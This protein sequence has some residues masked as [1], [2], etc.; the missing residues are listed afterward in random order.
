MLKKVGRHYR[1]SDA[2]VEQLLK[3]VHNKL[4]SLALQGNTELAS[5]L[6]TLLNVETKS[7]ISAAFRTAMDIRTSTLDFKNI[8]TTLDINNTN[9]SNDEGTIMLDDVEEQCSTSMPSFNASS[10]SMYSSMPTTPSAYTPPST[11]ANYFQS[12]H[13][14]MDQDEE[15]IASQ[16][17]ML[18]MDK[19][20]QDMSTSF[21]DMNVNLDS[22][23]ADILQIISNE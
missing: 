6:R 2:I 13:Q 7:E 8:S 20:L 3:P 17:S 22:D 1:L 10:A 12:K 16:G 14:S 11:F 15:Y 23:S 5:K 19:Y 18:H 9:R 21:N 4:Q